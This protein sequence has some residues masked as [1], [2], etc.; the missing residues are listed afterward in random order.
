MKN[1]LSSWKTTIAGLVVLGLS[2]A[3]A[4]GKITLEQYS[5]LLGGATAAGLV[6]SKD[7]NKTHSK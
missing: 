3:L 4:F 2:V 6:T 7:A 1:I 5:I